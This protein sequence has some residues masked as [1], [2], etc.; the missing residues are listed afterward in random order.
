MKTFIIFLSLLISMSLHAQKTMNEVISNA[1]SASD[2]QLPSLGMYVLSI[3]D[4]NKVLLSKTGRYIVKGTVTDMW[5]GLQEQGSQPSNFPVF[6]PLLDI[7]D[8]TLSFGDPNKPEVLAYVSFGCHQC[9]EVIQQILSP[10]FLSRHSVR[11]ML[12][13]N[14]E[15]DKLVA[16]NVYCASDKYS[17]FNQLFVAREFESIKSDCVHPQIDMNISL[18]N[19]Q[20][21]KA[22]PSTFFKDTN[23]V[24]LGSFPE[25][26]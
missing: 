23:M 3:E 10:N 1:M 26:I 11:I 14:T 2:K 5:D 9:A 12:V 24:Y 25:D 19:A 21:V 22:L 18:A 7:N 16:S 4:G 15:E 8:F 6:P 20:Y 17:V 13:S